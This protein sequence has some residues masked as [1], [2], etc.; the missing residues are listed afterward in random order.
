MKKTIINYEDN[1]NKFGVEI[2]IKYPG[3]IENDFNHDYYFYEIKDN[4]IKHI[5]KTFNSKDPEI[6]QKKAEEKEKLLSLFGNNLIFVEEIPNEYDCDSENCWF[7][8]TTKIGH[9]KI[10]WRKRVIYLD[11]SETILNNIKGT[12]LF[13]GEDTTTLDTGIHAWGYE[14]A[15]EYIN[16]LL[17][18]R[19]RLATPADYISYPWGSILNSTEHEMIA[20]DIMVILYKTGNVFRE[21]S[22]DEYKKEKTKITKNIINASEESRFMQVVN[23]CKNPY[24]ANSFCKNWLGLTV[25]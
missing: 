25:L 22:F 9:L 17:D 3:N 10:G 16:I 20:R 8:V 6:L 14:K 1:D 23:F 2:V 24:M 19:I 21:I 7:R 5:R 12:N 11:Y 13:P 4:V 18:E 15:K